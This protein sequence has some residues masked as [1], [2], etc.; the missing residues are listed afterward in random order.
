[1]KKLKNYSVSALT[2]DELNLIIGGSPECG[3]Y[4]VTRGG[5]TRWFESKSVAQAYANAWTS[6]GQPCV[7]KQ[8]ICY[9]T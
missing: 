8:F 4:Y 5:T 7:A 6:L 1:M 3:N 2:R 9:S